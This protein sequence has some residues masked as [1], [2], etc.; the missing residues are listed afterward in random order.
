MLSRRKLKKQQKENTAKWTPLLEK[1]KKN[2][3]IIT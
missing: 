1:Y 2:I 3:K